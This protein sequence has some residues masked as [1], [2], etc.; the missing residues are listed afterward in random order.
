M[1]AAEY[2]EMARGKTAALMDAAAARESLPVVVALA[3]GD[4]PSRELARLYA[5]DRPLAPGELAHAAA[6]AEATGARRW[7]LAEADRLLT[8]ALGHL[9]DVVPQPAAG[10]DLAHLARLATRRDR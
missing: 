1:S 4:R 2:V 5:L 7:T 6:L 10:A 9:A 8:E 3:A